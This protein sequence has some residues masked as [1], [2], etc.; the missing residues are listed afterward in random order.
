MLL[1]EG[2]HGYGSRTKAT[3]SNVIKA[4][5]NSVMATGIYNSVPYITG[6]MYPAYALTNE[7]EYFAEIT[8]A[9]FSGEYFGEAYRNDYYAFYLSQLKTFD[10]AGYQLCMSVWEISL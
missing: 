10:P 9:F 3:T 6:G 7:I 1:H 4:T 5:Y 8:E 2:A